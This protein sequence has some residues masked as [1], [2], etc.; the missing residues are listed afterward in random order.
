MLRLN[1]TYTKK[2]YDIDLHMQILEETKGHS[3]GPCVT[4]VASLM[5]EANAHDP[6]AT[7]ALPTYRRKRQS[8]QD[9]GPAN[10]RLPRQRPSYHQ[11]NFASRSNAF[12]KPENK[13]MEQQAAHRP[14]P[15]RE[16]SLAQ[17]M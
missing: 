15:L 7:R 10:R 12:E 4:F 9:A 3:R 1:H 11:V 16:T 14:I 6:G 8:V 17:P 13:E 5:V 2:A